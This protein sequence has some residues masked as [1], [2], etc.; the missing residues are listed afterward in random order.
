ML[1]SDCFFWGVLGS[2]MHPQPQTPSCIVVM[3]ALL[4]LRRTSSERR[5]THA[6]TKSHARALTQTC[7]AFSPLPYAQQHMA[8]EEGETHAEAAAQMQAAMQTKDMSQVRAPQSKKWAFRLY[9]QRCTSQSACVWWSLV[10][11]CMSHVQRSRARPPG[12]R[13]S[14]WCMSHSHVVSRGSVLE[15]GAKLRPP[16]FTSTDTPTTHPQQ[17]QQEQQQASQCHV[18]S[19]IYV[20]PFHQQPRPKTPG[21][22]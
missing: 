1:G 18:Y 14:F 15:T 10:V 7:P 20:P 2:S 8:E 12:A 6:L 19:L 17:Q 22:A 11:S 5:N 4:T 16:Q 13:G 21:G 9:K 3:L